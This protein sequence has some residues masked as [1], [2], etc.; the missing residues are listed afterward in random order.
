MRTRRTVLASGGAILVLAGAAWWYAD[1]TAPADC[2]SDPA[3]HD[4]TRVLRDRYHLDGVFVNNIR[5]EAGGWFS[6][7]RECSAEVAEIRGNVNAA[8][9]P[10]REVRYRI[11]R[12]A[13]S[14]EPEVTVV[15]GGAV[16]LA[17]PT[18]SWWERL[19]AWL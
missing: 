3:L 19:L 4:V 2:G 1:S 8:D 7:R 10:W 16:P 14:E 17:K 13:E 18:G 5:T 15:L 6:D 12:A 11:V 9:M